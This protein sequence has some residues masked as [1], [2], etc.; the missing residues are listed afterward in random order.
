MKNMRRCRFCALDHTRIKND[1]EI[2][3]SECIHLRLYM[4]LSGLEYKTDDAFDRFVCITF[5]LLGNTVLVEAHGP[6]A[7]TVEDHMK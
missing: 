7:S 2:D 6:Y 5:D 1:D 4:P 3:W